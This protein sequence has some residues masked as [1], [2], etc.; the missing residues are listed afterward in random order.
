[1]AGASGR[2]KLERYK[3]SAVILNP[4]L[5]FDSD[6]HDIEVRRDPLLG[7][8]SLIGLRLVE[9][10]ETLVGYT[11]YE[12]LDKL[13]RESSE[14]CFFCPDKVL[15]S[16]PKFEKDIIPE[17]RISIGESTLFPNL[18]PL[19]KYHAIIVPSK[20]HFLKPNDFTPEILNDAFVSTQKFISYLPT[21]ETL[22]GSL[23]SNYMPPAGASAVHPHLQLIISS[24]SLNYAAK[25]QDAVAAYNKKHGH[26]YWEDLIEVE[27]ELDERYIGSTG[28]IHWLTPFSP[29]KTNEVWGI[30]PSGRF[31]DKSGSII[32]DLA[33]GVSKVLAYYG[34]EDYSSFNLA[35]ELGDLTGD[36]STSRC[37][38][39]LVTRQN[40]SPGYR[41]GEHFFQH[42]L[43]TEVVV[44]PPEIVAGKLRNRFRGA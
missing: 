19:S 37:F 31:M 11:D 8:K 40:F 2:I 29:S 34:D 28:S 10:Y 3:E 26:E 44:I 15:T 13:V 20:K 18:F 25:I 4:L 24:D 32:M 35:L 1:M 14:K 38:I 17:G 23:N 36:E 22:Y 9:K 6:T 7:S 41:A 39:R 33:K 42:L 27:I 30:L 12:F 21:D 5:N 43:D 16:T